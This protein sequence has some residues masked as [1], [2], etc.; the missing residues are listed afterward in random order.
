MTPLEEIVFS[1]S[2][3]WV[4]SRPRMLSKTEIIRLNG[5]EESDNSEVLLTK[6]K[7]MAN[8]NLKERAWKRNS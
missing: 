5:K 3:A 2:K 7:I 1:Y 8:R 4:S 6:N